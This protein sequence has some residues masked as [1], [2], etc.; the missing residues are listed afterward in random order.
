MPPP[1]FGPEPPPLEDDGVA[2]LRVP[3]HSIEAEQSVLGA[4]LLQPSALESISETVNEADFYRHEHRTIFATIAGQVSASQE[5][6]VITVFEQLQAAGKALDCGG[7]VYLNELA[8][9][10]PSAANIGRYAKIVRERSIL[11]RLIAVSD[12][13]ATAAFNPQGKPLAELLADAQAAVEATTSAAAA[14][15]RERAPRPRILDLSA[16]SSTRAPERHW[17][18][19][20]WLGFDPTL[21]AAAGGVGKTLLAQQMATAMAIGRP[22]IGQISQPYHSML[23]ACE[24][25]ADEIWRRQERIS[26]QFEIGLDEPGANLV[27]QTRRGCD[28]VLLTPDRGEMRR[29]RFYEELRQ[30]VNDLGVEVLFLDNVAH[31]FAGD[32]MNRSHVTQFVNA[33]AGLV[34]GRPFGVVMLSHISRRDGSEYSGSAAW[35]NACRMRWYLGTTLPDQKP[36]EGDS[37]TEDV[38]YLARRKSNY[39]RRDYVKFTM[40]RGVLVPDAAPTHVS[41][42]MAKVDEKRCEEVV[43]A[44]FRS[45]LAMGIKPTDG[46]T[47]RDYLPALIVAKNLGLG[48]SRNDLTRAKDRLMVAGKI[49]RGIVG[50]YSNR[51]PKEG[52]VITEKGSS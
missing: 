48:F 14:L 6:D 10:V 49:A 27:L 43:L 15:G 31:L 28:S 17:P 50:T 12:N 25:D 22:F 18:V 26:D 20:G 13:I 32:E 1:D 16:L 24:D 21:F 3:P 38:R 29:T 47:S 40:D 45:L 4:L 35:E 41:A 2:R 36:E 11:R 9:C 30:Q 51:T 52:L 44:A 37:Q 42:V 34:G 23:V 5:V 33:M 46:A 19:P 7:L 8:C 39:S